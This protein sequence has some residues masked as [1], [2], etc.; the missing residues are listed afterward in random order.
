MWDLREAA[1]VL[2]AELLRPKAPYAARGAC[3]DSRRIRPGE[4]FVALPGQK[5]DGHEFLAEAFSRGAVGALVS[6]DPGIGHNLILVPEVKRPCG[7][8]PAGGGSPWI[9]SPLA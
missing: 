4:L 1:E 6:H 3:A 8:W 2:E 5:H 9:S 7:I